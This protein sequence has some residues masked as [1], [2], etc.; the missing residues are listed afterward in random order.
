MDELTHLYRMMA[1]APNVD[2][3]IN[4]LKEVSTKVSDI[5]KPLPKGLEGKDTIE[6]RS[7][8][9]A[10]LTSIIDTLRITREAKKQHKGSFDPDEQ[11]PGTGGTTDDDLL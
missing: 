5:R 9:C 7:A 3:F 2:D 11:D 6:V 8:A 1:G 4:L 10:I